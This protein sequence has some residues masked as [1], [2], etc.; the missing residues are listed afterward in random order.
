MDEEPYHITALESGNC[1][2][3]VGTSNGLLL[4]MPLPK[5]PDSVPKIT[6]PFP[7]LH[8]FSAGDKR[9]GKAL[10]L[11]PTRISEQELRFIEFDAEQVLGGAL[12]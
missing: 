12:H 3:Y 8:L 9:T 2:L 4:V 1:Q 6:G 11:R 10:Q 7:S 5:L